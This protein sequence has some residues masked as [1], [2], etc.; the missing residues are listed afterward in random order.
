MIDLSSSLATCGDRHHMP[1]VWVKSVDS[2]I[3]ALLITK[4]MSLRKH[5]YSNILKIL[6]P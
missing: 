1:S 4:S 3:H 5:A 6:P 2:M